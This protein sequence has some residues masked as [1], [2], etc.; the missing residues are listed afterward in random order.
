MYSRLLWYICVIIAILSCSTLA[1]KT[2]NRFQSSPTVITMDRNKFSWNTSFPTLTVCPHK[3]IDEHKVDAYM[4][5]HAHIF[6]NRS[7]RAD[8]HSFVVAL[9]NLTYDTIDE[10]PMANTFG[11]ESRHYMELLWNC[12]WN[13]L[14]E[15]SSGSGV[16]MYLQDVVTEVGVCYTFN[17]K[18]SA[19]S[20][21]R[22][23]G[24]RHA[25]PVLSVTGNNG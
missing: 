23:V 21:F 20:S 7:V 11:I 17:S 2:W 14:P 13:F 5:Q 24:I 4:R 12:T 9:A 22:L 1:Q 16:K 18:I 6:E 8:F 3:R 19:Y 15:V 25:L 10:L